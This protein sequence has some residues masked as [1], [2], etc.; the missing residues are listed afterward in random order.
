MFNWSVNKVYRALVVISGLTIGSNTKSL[1]WRF[2]NLLGR[3]RWAWEQ[4]HRGGSI[5][6]SFASL[7]GLFLP[8]IYTLWITGLSCPAKLFELI[9]GEIP[10][11]SS[12]RSSNRVLS[13]TT[14]GLT[15]C[16]GITFQ[17]GD[18]CNLNYS[19]PSHNNTF[20]QTLQDFVW[21]V[22]IP[23]KLIRWIW[24]IV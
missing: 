22:S 8:V 21:F 6:L 4:A 18:N 14:A 13:T 24:S 12:F 9:T 2:C 3:E 11:S 23:V 16:V 1:S 10:W 19:K 17:E 20:C 5:V 7:L 15:H